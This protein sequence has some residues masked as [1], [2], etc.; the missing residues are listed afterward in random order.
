MS[1][2]GSSGRVT[3]RKLRPAWVILGDGSSVQGPIRKLRPAWAM[4]GDGSSGQP[5][6]KLRLQLILAK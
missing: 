6:R 3:I 1:G 2:D 4:P 5:I